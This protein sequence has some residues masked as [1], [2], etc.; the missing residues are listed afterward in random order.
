M[1]FTGFLD[2]TLGK[3]VKT[4]AYVA[5]SAVLGYLISAT[6][7]TPDLFGAWTG[8]INVALVAL[9]G[10]LTPDQPNLPK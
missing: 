7:N 2:T 1:D 9:K 6:T 3:V 10:L 5:I 4:A 8:T